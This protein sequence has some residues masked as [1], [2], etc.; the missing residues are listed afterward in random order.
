MVPQWFFFAAL[1][2]LA[3][4]IVA[5]NVWDFLPFKKKPLD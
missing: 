2:F 3:I 5:V 1:A 4:F